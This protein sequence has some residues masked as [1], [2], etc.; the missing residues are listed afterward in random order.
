MGP[1]S[2]IMGVGAYSV[3]GVEPSDDLQRHKD[4]VVVLGGDVEA[5]Q[6]AVRL[7]N[8]RGVS[9]RAAQSTSAI[10]CARWALFLDWGWRKS[11]AQPSRHTVVAALLEARNLPFVRI[12]SV[13]SLERA[14]HSLAG[15]AL[16]RE[17]AGGSLREGE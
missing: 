10:G 13:K 3:H 7:L 11:S 4:E 8:D 17:Q 14:V 15:F 6:R 1:G 12:A 5:V 2:P 16:G 9:A